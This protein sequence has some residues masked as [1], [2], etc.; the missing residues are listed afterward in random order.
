[1]FLQINLD[2]PATLRSW[3][4]MDTLSPMGKMYRSYPAVKTIRVFMK[5]NENYAFMRNPIKI[6][7]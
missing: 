5:V 1:M 7:F 3:P 2:M 6:E 4:H